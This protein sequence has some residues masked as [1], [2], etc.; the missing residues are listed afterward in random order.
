MGFPPALP[1]FAAPST[2]EEDTAIPESPPGNNNADADANANTNANANAIAGMPTETSATSTKAASSRPPDIVSTLTILSTR[3][4]PPLS[5]I[6]MATYSSTPLISAATTEAGISGHQHLPGASI[7][8]IVISA[9]AGLSLIVALA[10]VLLRRK[11][12]PRV[13]DGSQASVGR[14]WDSKGVRV[15]RNF[16]HE[17]PADKDKSG[18]NTKTALREIDADNE[19]G[20][21][22]DEVERR[23]LDG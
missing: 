2:D 6:S 5:E 10:W 22:G 20:E 4:F 17:H 14:Q 11:R 21:L 7:A 12:L 1:T 19:L 23:E 3:T 18:L 16:R 13:K 8:G 15:S 9:L